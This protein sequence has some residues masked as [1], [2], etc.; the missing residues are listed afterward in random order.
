MERIRKR[1]EVA[2]VWGPVA[3]WELRAFWKHGIEAIADPALRETVAG[4]LADVS[5]VQFF[6]YAAGTGGKY[7]PVWQNRPFGMLRNTT[8]CCAMIPKMAQYFPGIVDR[9]RKLIP[10]KVDAALA[11]TIVSDTFKFDEK[12]EKTGAAHGEIAANRWREYTKERGTISGAAAHQIEEAVLWHY[13]IYAPQWR[14]GV[15]LS[16]LIQLVHL[17]DAF[18]AQKTLELLY[19]P[20]SVIE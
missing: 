15:P 5:P 3:E 18:F 16:P 6:T 9:E 20:K 4:F 17:V 13:G 11:A 12:G 14:P 8:E 2:G 7:H 10:E 1:L 19:H